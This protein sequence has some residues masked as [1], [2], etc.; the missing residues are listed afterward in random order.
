MLL[1][2]AAGDEEVTRRLAALQGE[3]GR[4]GWVEGLNLRYET[5]WAG[6]DPDRIGMA[7]NELVA[8]VPD[9]I[10]ANGSSAM[11][12]MQRVT[13]T[14]PVVFVVVPDPV[15]AGYVDTL[16]RPGGNATGF[17]N[18]NLASAANGWSFSKS[19]RRD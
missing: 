5:R 1:V 10:V 2:A 13:R 19:L 16:A 11:D 17:D 4:L 3:L 6:G 15:G 9:L 18:S 7:A 14:V 12:A 8:L